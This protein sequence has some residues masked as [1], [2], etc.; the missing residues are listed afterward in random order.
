MALRPHLSM[1]MPLSS[2]QTLKFLKFHY[3]LTTFLARCQCIIRKFYINSDDPAKG[4]ELLKGLRKR[5]LRYAALG[6]K[7]AFLDTHSSAATRL[8]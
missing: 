2:E 7:S 3:N 4:N 8:P 5:P 6:S 1:A